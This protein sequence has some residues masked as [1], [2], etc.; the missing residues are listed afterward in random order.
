MM[1]QTVKKKT[2]MPSLLA[3]KR[4]DILKMLSLSLYVMTPFFHT[5]C[6][7]KMLHYWPTLN[8]NLTLPHCNPL[9]YVEET[10]ERGLPPL[11]ASDRLI[12]DANFISAQVKEMH[13]RSMG[14]DHIFCHFLQRH[15][16][17][18]TRLLDL[19][20]SRIEQT[21]LPTNNQPTTSNTVDLS[22]F[23]CQS[24][25]VI[26]LATRGRFGATQD[27][28]YIDKV[29]SIQ[30]HSFMCANFKASE[31]FFMSDEDS[32]PFLILSAHMLMSAAYPVAALKLVQA[33]GDRLRRCGRM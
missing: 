11:V 32:I 5:A 17:I 25:L 26:N 18:L 29:E 19:F 23:D 15:S 33:A 10:V 3:G 16:N 31:L 4:S 22:Q 8:L 1:H 6:S 2:G 21:P 30:A 13:E 28:N 7:H 14:V 27:D 20:A 12:V 24:I 9:R